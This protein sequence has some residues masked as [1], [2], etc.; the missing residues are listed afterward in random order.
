MLIK[1]LNIYKITLLLNNIWKLVLIKKFKR[2]FK[3]VAKEIAYN[4]INKLVTI[5]TLVT[6]KIK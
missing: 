6:T 4:K 5:R 1:L 2:I 3:L